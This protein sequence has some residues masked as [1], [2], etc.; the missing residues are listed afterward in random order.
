[1]FL[2]NLGMEN[3]IESGYFEAIPPSK[4]Y[5]TKLQILRLL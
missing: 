3:Q 2:I 4:T 1:M 5:L